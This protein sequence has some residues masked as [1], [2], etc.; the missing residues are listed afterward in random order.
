RQLAQRLAAAGVTGILNFTSTKIDPG[1]GVAVRV[2]DIAVELEGL[3][4]TILTGAR[5]VG[6]S[7]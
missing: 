2:M 1:P 3:S 7:P 6:T 4:Y 5:A